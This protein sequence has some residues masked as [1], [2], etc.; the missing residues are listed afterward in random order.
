MVRRPAPDKSHSTSDR[1]TVTSDN[2][3]TAKRLHKSRDSNPAAREMESA[4]RQR[5]IR[6]RPSCSDP[7]HV[8]PNE[9][10]FGR[11]HTFCSSRGCPARSRS[12]ALYLR[13]SAKSVWQLFLNNGALIIENHK[14]NRLRL[15]ID[16]LVE[17]M[18]RF[19]KYHAIPASERPPSEAHA[20][21]HAVNPIKM[22]NNPSHYHVLRPASL[23]PSRRSCAPIHRRRRWGLAARVF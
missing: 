6:N 20:G 19:Q 22:K 1:T 9:P 4:P 11:R 7:A 13:C 18:V 10:H 5:M 2:R 3:V 12:K 8:D 14:H 16:I 21:A 17:H 23:L 15:V